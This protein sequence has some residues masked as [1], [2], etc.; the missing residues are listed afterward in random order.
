[1]PPTEWRRNQAWPITFPRLALVTCMFAHVWHQF[2]VFPRLVPVACFPALGTR[3]MFSAFGTDSMF[4]AN[5]MFSPRLKMAV[6]FPALGA[7]C[8]GF[9]FDIF[10][11]CF[12][13]SHQKTYP[14]PLLIAHAT[15]IIQCSSF[16]VSEIPTYVSGVWDIYSYWSGKTVTDLS[17]AK[18][19]MAHAWSS[20]RSDWLF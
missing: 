2:Y 13:N 7:S 10:C 9:F 5:C 8:T 20:R 19:Y 6:C 16:A 4:G 3:L 11:F 15:T 18:R 12:T 14:F 17:M 1:M